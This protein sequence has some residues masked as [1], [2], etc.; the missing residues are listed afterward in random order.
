VYPP[1]VSN[2]QTSIPDGEYTARVYVY[3]RNGELPLA[4]YMSQPF[5]H[6]YPSTG[7]ADGYNGSNIPTR[8]Y[9]FEILPTTA[10]ACP[11]PTVGATSTTVPVCASI[12]NSL[13]LSDCF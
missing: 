11:Q 10:S 8:T 9:D 2:D 7:V 3:S 12:S 4:V 5:Q 6:S 1:G 13:P